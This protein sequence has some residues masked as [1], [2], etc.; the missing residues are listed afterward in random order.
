MENAWGKSSKSIKL[1]EIF[2]LMN[3]GPFWKKLI[4]ILKMV[5]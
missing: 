5:K 1:L 2:I 3:Y 4:H